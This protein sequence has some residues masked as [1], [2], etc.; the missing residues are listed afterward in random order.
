MKTYS[1]P[2][3]GSS[4]I[5]S[6]PISLAAINTHNREASLTPLINLEKLLRTANY[7]NSTYPDRSP[8]QDP[9][10]VQEYAKAMS[11]GPDYPQIIE[12]RA[13]GLKEV[14]GEQFNVATYSMTIPL[15]EGRRSV[16]LTS[17]GTIDDK[18]RGDKSPGLKEKMYQQYVFAYDGKLY[19][20]PS[21]V[22]KEASEYFEAMRKAFSKIRP[23]LNE[24]L[25]KEIY[26]VSVS[27][28]GNKFEVTHIGNL[29][30]IKYLVVLPKLDY[31]KAAMNDKDI[32]PVPPSQLKEAA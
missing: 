30:G 2:S 22:R 3:Y 14:P 16:T 7:P 19:V 24:K 28:L 11:L 29:T 12:Q 1:G 8:I 5:I 10:A 20:M 31:N 18:I 26:Q 17:T 13:K 27:D 23:D 9:K 21:Q 25:R 15:A 32:L 4:P 6:G